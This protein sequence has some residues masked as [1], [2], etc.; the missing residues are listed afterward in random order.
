MTITGISQG[1]SMH[2][3]RKTGCIRMVTMKKH[4]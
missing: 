2:Q 3:L 4:R 1:I